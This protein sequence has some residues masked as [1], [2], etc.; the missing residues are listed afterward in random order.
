MI[1]AK[2]S[3]FPELPYT[4]ISKQHNWVVF[5]PFSRLFTVLFTTFFCRNEEKGVICC[6]AL[7][8]LSCMGLLD[9]LKKAVA[10]AGAQLTSS[11]PKPQSITFTPN[12]YEKAKQWHL[13]E[14]DALDVYY[15]GEEVKAGKK[16]RKYNGYA[17]YIY[18]G[19][20]PITGNPYISTI[21]KQE[22]R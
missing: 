15:H 1:F 3:K 22:R 8:Y 9:G 11:S 12:F 7:L 18:Y 21:W 14:K 16:A 19:R 4:A 2:P 10:T 13:G 17:L 5:L 20:N 6:K